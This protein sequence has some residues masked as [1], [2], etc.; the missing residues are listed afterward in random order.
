MKK[1]ESDKQS[2]RN[3]SVLFCVVLALGLFAFLLDHFL[4]F[5]VPAISKVAAFAQSIITVIVGIWITCYLLF[6]ELYKDRYPIESLKIELLPHMR[7]NFILVIYDVVYGGILVFFDY[8]FCGSIW[9]LIVTLETIIIIFVDVFRAHQTLM[10][11]SYV[12]KFFSKVSAAFNSHTGAIDPHFF[13][14]IK[15]ILAESLSK[16]EFYTAQTIIEQTGSSFRDYLG[17]LVKLSDKIGSDKV[18][19][20]FREVVAFNI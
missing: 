20:S 19:E 14:E 12:S 18:E 7:N 16:E 13:G 11:S 4:C 17:N 9:F 6:M 8:S 10:V 1:R 3:H 2:K 15:F 5:D